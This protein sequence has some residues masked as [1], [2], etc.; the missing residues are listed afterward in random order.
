MT[1]INI[2]SLFFPLIAS[3]LMILELPPY[4][5]MFPRCYERKSF[6]NLTRN[7]TCPW[8]PQIDLINY[9]KFSNSHLIWGGPYFYPCTG[10]SRVFNPNSGH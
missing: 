3:L 7:E 6:H 2:L 9:V 5:A 8:Q 4:V 1:E 10:Q